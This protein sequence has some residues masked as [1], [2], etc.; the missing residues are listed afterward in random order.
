M[1]SPPRQDDPPRAKRRRPPPTKGEGAGVDVFTIKMHV[2]AKD[3]RRLKQ[4]SLD[5]NVSLNKLS[6]YAWN[7]LLGELGMD[8]LEPTPARSG[9]MPPDEDN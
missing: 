2:S 9:S 7:L 3:R 1:P 5:K 4:L 6:H 8:D